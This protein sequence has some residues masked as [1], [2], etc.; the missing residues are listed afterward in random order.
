MDSHA[1]PA[2]L[3]SVVFIAAVA[4]AIHGSLLVAAP[5]SPPVRALQMSLHV[6]TAIAY[7]CGTH[8]CV[9]IAN[10]Y[11][12]RS[13][14]RLAW[15]LIAASAG[16]AVVRHSFEGLVLATGWVD[17]MLTTLVSLRQLPIAVSLILL[18][19]GLV[20]VWSSFTS[21]GM[22]LR[23]RAADVLVLA[24]IL[25]FVPSILSLRE[26][27]SDAQSVYPI[28]RH[29]QSASPLLLAIPALVSLVLHRISQEMGGGQLALSLRCMVAFLL[30]RMLALLLGLFPGVP[31]LTVASR[32]VWW[33]TAGLFLLAVFYRWQVT[34]SAS[35]LADR[36]EADPDAE[37]AGISQALALRSLQHPVSKH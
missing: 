25:A 2:R 27:M 12:D 18:T 24:V 35:E 26:E 33:S 20:A 16:F 37:L 19:A 23:F 8:V 4:G 1:T 3:W 31:A 22:G 14:M 5:G 21:I 11:R 6:L 28:I 15:R 7:G 32:T 13:T 36:Y 34:L 9:K 29:L 10:D 30:M 17:T